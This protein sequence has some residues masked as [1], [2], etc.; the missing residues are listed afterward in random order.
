MVE[1]S[2]FIF[3]GHQ[4]REASHVEVGSTEQE[5]NL[6]TFLKK[7]TST[8]KQTLINQKSALEHFF[9]VASARRRSLWWFFELRK[10]LRC[11]A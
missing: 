9:L 6:F 10:D 8:S 11:F 7:R 4:Q 1:A 3:S 5:V 2:S